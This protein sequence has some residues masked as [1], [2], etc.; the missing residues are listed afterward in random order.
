MRTNTAGRTAV[1]V[2]RQHR[3]VLFQHALQARLPVD[4]HVEDHDLPLPGRPLH[5]QPE[6][7]RALFPKRPLVQVWENC[8][9]VWMR[10]LGVRRAC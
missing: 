8:P 5:L 6:W 9:R 2:T 3:R 4:A 1:L 10:T 7:H